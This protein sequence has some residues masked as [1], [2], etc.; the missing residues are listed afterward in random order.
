MSE[1]KTIKRLAYNNDLM[2]MT[3]ISENK[4]LY[5]LKFVVSPYY[6]S[7]SSLIHLDES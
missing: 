2:H 6:I 4:L 7:S 3:A 5:L 1:S